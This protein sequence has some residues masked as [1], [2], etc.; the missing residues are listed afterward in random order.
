MEVSESRMALL[1][2][3]IKYEVIL[4]HEKH[5]IGRYK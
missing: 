5:E 3:N 4:G 2:V 1:K